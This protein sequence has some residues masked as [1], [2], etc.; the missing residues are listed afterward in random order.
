MYIRLCEQER[1]HSTLPVH[2]SVKCEQEGIS[3][4]NSPVKDVTARD[5]RDQRLS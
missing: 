1:S 4:K 5:E 3:H 2:V